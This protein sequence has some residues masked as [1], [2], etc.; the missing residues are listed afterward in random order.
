M[1]EITGEG[2]YAVA[3]PDRKIRKK[4]KKKKSSQQ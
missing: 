4:K 1:I 3:T 2:K